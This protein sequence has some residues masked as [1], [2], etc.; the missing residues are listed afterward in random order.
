MAAAVDSTTV[1]DLAVEGKTVK[2]I[3]L[4]SVKRTFDLFA[5]NHGEAA[6]LDEER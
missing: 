6:P 4:L 2:T 1:A 5:G 3:T